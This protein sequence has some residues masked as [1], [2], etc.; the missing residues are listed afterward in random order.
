MTGTPASRGSLTHEPDRFSDPAWELL[1]AGQDM[2]RR[3]R[4]DQLDVEHLIQVL[5]SDSSFRR[6]V[7]PLPLRSDDL[8]DRLEDVLADQPP[9]RG[10]QLF[11]GEDLEQLL[12]T[13]D[14]VRG[15]WGDRLID[16][17]QLIVAVGADP[18][19][20]AE[21]F[22]A[23]GLA[24]DRLESLLRQPS[25]SPAPAPPPVPTAASAPAPTPRSAPAPRVMAPEPEPTVELEREPSALE[26]YGRDLTEEAEAGSLDPVIGRDSEIRNLIKVLSRRSKNNPVLIGEPGVGK[27]AI[28]ELLAQR[29]VAGEVPDSL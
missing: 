3:W 5:F 1:L 20:G 27:T 18:R 9:A 11:I 28:A 19:I 8:L 17:P 15:R 2:A 4:H 12:E 26:A 23:Q 10:D 29:I 6:W 7:E 16:V 14:Q 21:L 24:V 22:A 13:A 25:V